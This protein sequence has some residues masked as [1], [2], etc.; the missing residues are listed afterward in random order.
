MKRQII[1]EIICLLFIFLFTYAAASKLIDIQK[2]QIQLGQSPLLSEIAIPIS[3][4]IPI[5]ELL[6][7]G[8]LMIRRFR[9][10]GLISSTVIMVMFTSYIFIIMNYSEQIPCSCGGVLRMLGW[11]EHLIFNIVFVVLGTTGILLHNKFSKHH[12]FKD[13][14]LQ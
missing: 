9:K 12:T 14:L 8:A 6:I 4:I 2:F 11:K 7:A 3:W 13:I 5:G 1:Q 10:I